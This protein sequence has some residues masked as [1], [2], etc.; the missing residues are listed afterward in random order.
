MRAVRAGS[1]Q[2][3]A[4]RHDHRPTSDPEQRTPPRRLAADDPVASRSRGPDA[5]SGEHVRLSFASGW[6][7]RAVPDLALEAEARNLADLPCGTSRAA[8]RFPAGRPPQMMLR[9]GYGRPGART[10]RRPV[11]D[12]LDIK[13]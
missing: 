10:P 4:G 11:Q 12:V 7:L 5:A 13:P 8:N 9:P 3:C 2:V 6:H 1:I